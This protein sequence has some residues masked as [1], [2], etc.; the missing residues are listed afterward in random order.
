VPAP[1]LQLIADLAPGLKKISPNFIVDPRPNKGSLMR[2]YRDIRFSKDKSPYDTYAAARFWQANGKDAVA[3]SYFLHLEPGNSEDE[4]EQ[5]SRQ[6]VSWLSRPP[7]P[8][9]HRALFL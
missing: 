5:S 7:W 3:P 1:F 2:I 9:Q 6:R 4:P 8:P